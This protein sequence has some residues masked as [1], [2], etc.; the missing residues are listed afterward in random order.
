MQ[1]QRSMRPMAKKATANVRR[2]QARKGVLRT[3]GLRQE[4]AEAHARGIPVFELRAENW[5]ETR[6]IVIE[7]A[8]RAQREAE[9]IKRRYW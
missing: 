8:L 5:Q 7:A 6:Q 4:R 1:F 9:A 2:S 3:Q